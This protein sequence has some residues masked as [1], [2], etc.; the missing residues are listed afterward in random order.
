MASLVATAQLGS[1][2]AWEADVDEAARLALGRE[3]LR[4]MDCARC[5]GR[6]YDGWAAPSLIAAV[7]DYPRERFEVIVLDGVPQRGMPGYRTQPVVAN[8]LDAIYRFLLASARYGL[9]TGSQP[10]Q[11]RPPCA[12]K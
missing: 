11:A 8:Q 12:L 4:A 1:A 10:P 7:Q 3:A 6:D 9:A 2:A 5:H